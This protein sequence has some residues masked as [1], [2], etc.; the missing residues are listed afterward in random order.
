MTTET[1]IAWAAGLFEGE[2]CFS[3][4][5]GKYLRCS[6]NTTDKDVLERFVK[7]VG[8]GNILDYKRGGVSPLTKKDGWQWS[9]SGKK[10]LPV[11]EMLRPYLGARRQ[12]RLAE[13]LSQ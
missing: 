5:N 9:V 6:M 12:M 3:L 7:I 2:G 8:V 4:A 1:D 10:A 11:A 13:I